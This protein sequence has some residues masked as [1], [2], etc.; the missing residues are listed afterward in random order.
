MPLPLVSVATLP[1]L[2][3]PGAFAHS[4][5]LAS[6]EALVPGSDAFHVTGMVVAAENACEPA[7]EIGGVVSFAIV[8]VTLP[9]VRFPAL[10]VAR[11]D[12]T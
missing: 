8:N 9:T 2:A 3:A 5:T 11:A 6:P 10:S 1:K 12:S 4:S 7:S